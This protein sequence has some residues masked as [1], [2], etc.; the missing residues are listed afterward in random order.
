MKKKSSKS[1]SFR[2]MAYARKE[3]RELTPKKEIS[4]SSRSD[5]LDRKKNHPVKNNN[6]LSL[7]I[8]QTSAA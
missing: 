3:V 8:S 2:D 6:L 4:P 7:P 5:N 1:A